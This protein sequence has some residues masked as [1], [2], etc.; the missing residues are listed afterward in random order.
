MLKKNIIKFIKKIRRQIYKIQ[1]ILLR[2]I[3]KKSKYRYGINNKDRD[4]PKVI[5]S[6]TTFP[7]RIGKIDLC[8]KSI[9][10]QNFKPDRIIFWLGNDT[11][12]EI[13]EEYLGKYK[14]YGV[15]YFIDSDNNYF[16]HKKYIYAFQK[17][18]NCL[19]ITLDDDL[20]Y[21]KSLIKSLIK[22]YKKFPNSIIARR[23][24][25]ITFN[26][27]TINQ[28]NKWNWECFTIKKPSF[29]LIATTGAGTL[30][31]PNIFNSSDLDFD[32][33]KEYALTADDIWLKMMAVKNNVRVVWAGNFLQMPVEI[34]E[35][36]E[37]AL[38]N[39]NVHENKN[40][41]YIKNI[42]RDF[43]INP[44]ILKDEI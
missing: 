43:Q 30:F 44:S 13:A 37:E 11:K 28:Y 9:L 17:Y 1:K 19:N 29:K 32:K 36:N 21:S 41:I 12:E 34:E 33:I 3:V 5:V 35:N 39:V 23:V 22:K 10:R 26:D 31:P 25:E 6:I 38:S 27:K 20:I 14:K 18:S 42:M 2:K 40:D 7:A 16:S 15:E 24:H 4:L 8:I